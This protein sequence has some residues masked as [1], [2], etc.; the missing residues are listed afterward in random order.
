MESFL[1]ELSHP[2]QNA[3]ALTLSLTP[4]GET[5]GGNSR[6]G[7]YDTIFFSWSVHPWHGLGL[8]YWNGRVHSAQSHGHPLTLK[9]IRSPIPWIT[10]GESIRAKI[11]LS[12]SLRI[13]ANHKAHIHTNCFLKTKPVK[14]EAIKVSESSTQTSSLQARMTPCSFPDALPSQ[15]MEAADILLGK[16]LSD[17][18]GS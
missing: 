10:S 17:S 3:L 7:L 18:T 13:H 9:Q 4:F 2:A 5:F 8:A 12:V 15:I 6:S 1:S 14:T 11:D 16:G